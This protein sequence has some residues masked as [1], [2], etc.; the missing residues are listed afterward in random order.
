MRFFDDIPQPLVVFSPLAKIIL[1]LFLSALWTLLP[2]RSFV[3][4]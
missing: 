2:L 4:L 3:H 1:A